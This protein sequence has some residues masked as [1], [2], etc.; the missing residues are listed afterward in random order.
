[1]NVITIKYQESPSLFF[2]DPSQLD[3]ASAETRPLVQE[4]LDRLNSIS[5]KGALTTWVIVSVLAV[6][7]FFA[8]F[9]LVFISYFV[10]ALTGFAT[11]LFIVSIIMFKLNL[12]K[13]QKKVSAICVEYQLRLATSYEVRELSPILQRSSR[14]VTHSEVIILTQ[15]PLEQ[16]RPEPLLA[17]LEQIPFYSYNPKKKEL[18]NNFVIGSENELLTQPITPNHEPQSPLPKNKLT[19]TPTI[20]SITLHDQHAN[21]AQPPRLPELDIENPLVEVR[22]LP[23]TPQNATQPADLRLVMDSVYVIPGRRLP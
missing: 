22:T 13:V 17:D 15:I 2:V 23:P 1:M 3:R 10:F 6:I 12:R 11:I 14:T 7:L 5:I 19:S 21:L 8:S 4:F 16:P 9:F 18:G 20:G